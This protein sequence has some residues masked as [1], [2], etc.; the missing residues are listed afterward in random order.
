MQAFTLQG[1]Y[2]VWANFSKSS[3]IKIRSMKSLIG[4]YWSF[5]LNLHFFANG[6]WKIFPALT[7]SRKIINV[8]G[9]IGLYTQVWSESAGYQ[10]RQCELS[11]SLTFVKG[12]WKSD[13]KVNPKFYFLNTDTKGSQARYSHYLPFHFAHNKM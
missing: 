13:T 4:F 12:S 8:I 6:V 10:H 1:K 3:W 11:N 7:K 5:I 9:N 2:A